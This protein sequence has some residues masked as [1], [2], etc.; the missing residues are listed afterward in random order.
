MSGDTIRSLGAGALVA[1][2]LCACGRSGQSTTETGGD[3]VARVNGEVIT[4]GQLNRKLEQAERPGEGGAPALRRQALDELIDE[5]LLVQKAVAAG[6]DRQPDT[7]SAIESLRSQWLARAVVES[8]EAARGGDIQERDVRAFFE[9]NPDLFSRRKVYTFHRFVVE[10][11]R[12]DRTTKVRLDSARTPASVAQ[13]LRAAGLAHSRR[14]ET[15]TAEALSSAA[16]ARA[17]RMVPGDLLLVREGSRTVLLQ[18]VGAVV[19][20]LALEAA[21]PSIERYLAGVR[22]QE[23]AGRMLKDLRLAA[24]I[25]YVTQT[26]ADAKPTT[27][28][29]GQPALNE[30]PSHKSLQPP[31]TIVVR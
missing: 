11:G 19:E 27:L 31:Q 28:A 25:E 12:L 2:L 6:L 26:A 22:R 9:A 30:P 15:L 7:R 17:A 8:Q 23:N 14:T 18:L 20:P 5:R 3:I 10:R 16:L 24:T 13:A 29:D 4:V 1:L 21:A